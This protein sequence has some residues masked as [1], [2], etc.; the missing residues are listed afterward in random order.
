MTR[1][2]HF[3]AIRKGRWC[4]ERSEA[5]GTATRMGPFSDLA[6]CLSDARENGFDETK[7]E[8]RVDHC[9]PDTYTGLRHVVH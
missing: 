2:W 8:R 5:N 7:L 6:T 3:F 9:N 1:R 4:W